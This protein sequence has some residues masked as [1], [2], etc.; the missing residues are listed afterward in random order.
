[1]ESEPKLPSRTVTSEAWKPQA[2][3]AEPNEDTVESTSRMRIA[4]SAPERSIG[5]GIAR[6]LGLDLADCHG[7][8]T[9]RQESGT[10]RAG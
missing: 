6:Q 2:S 7:E 8:H 1:M 4:V 9:R 5:D 10:Q 3:A